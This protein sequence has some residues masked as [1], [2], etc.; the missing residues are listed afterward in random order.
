MDVVKAPRLRRGGAA[1]VVVAL[2]A[3]C[4]TSPPEADGPALVLRAGQ[5]SEISSLDPAIGYD[6]YSW[7]WKRLIFETLLTYDDGA[8]LVPRLAERMPD[9]SDDGRTLTFEI[10]R[11]V[12]FVTPDGQI[13]R[14]LTAGDFAYSLSRLLRQDL[15]PTPSD[16]Q[17]LYELIV[18]ADAVIAG[19]AEMAV[20]VQAT[21]VY[22]LQ[23][24]TSEPDPTFLNVLAMPFGSVVPREHAGSDTTAFSQTPVGTGPYLLAEWT[25]GVSARFVRNPHYWDASRQPVP[26]IEV[27]LGLDANGQ[28]QQVQTGALHVMTDAIPAGQFNAIAEDARWAEYL[29]RAPQVATG[30]LAM[31]TTQE[32]PLGNVLVRRA[33]SH[34]VDR[35]NIVRIRNGRGVPGACIYPPELPGHDPDCNPYPY[36]PDRARQLLSDAG[37]ASG[38]ATRLYSADLEADVQIAQAIQQDLAQVGITA[39]LVPQPEDVL[40]DSIYT[41][42]Q[43][44]L[45]LSGWYMDFPDPANFIEPLLTCASVGA[46]FNPAWYCNE[47]VDQLVAEARLENDAARRIEIF[48]QIELLVMEDAPWV[49]TAYPELTVLVH[50]SVTKFRLHPIWRFDFENYELGS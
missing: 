2:L 15:S 14:E 36:D 17:S 46:V 25:P 20:G 13:L 45:F 22:T 3:A 49:V 43:T 30:F 47:R 4:G 6:I 33:I 31:D 35:Q 7:P 39:E 48:R 26:A 10:R 18:G 21:D 27:L 40:F 41:Q 1:L 29:Q 50:P 23:I 44:P 5:E 8:V 19:S 37:F 42:H 28:L 12:N 32:G 16:A 34:A 11:G 24:T 38:F 9:V